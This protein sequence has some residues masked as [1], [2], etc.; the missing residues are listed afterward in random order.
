MKSILSIIITCISIAIYSQSNMKTTNSLI[1]KY[2]EELNKIRED[3]ELLSEFKFSTDNPNHFERLRLNIA[4]FNDFKETDFWIAKYLFEQESN[5]RKSKNYYD[6]GEVDNLYFSAFL[7][8]KYH[9]PEM[10]AKFFETKMIDFDTGIGFDGEFLLSN[11]KKET[12]K[13]LSSLDDELKEKIYKYIG[14]SLETCEY[15]DEDLENWKDFKYQYFKIYILPIEDEMWFLYLTREKEIM[16]NKFKSWIDSQKNWSNENI[17]KYELYSKYL[18][19]EE[20]L[21]IAKELKIK[22]K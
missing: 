13:F 4:L 2:T 1:E 6:N 3:E 5:W 16:K 17:W 15:K 8:S 12:Y 21:K 22:L 19:D 18:E 11:G 10:V 7:V 20:N 9:K 14:N